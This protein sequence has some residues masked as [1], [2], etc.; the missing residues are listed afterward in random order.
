MGAYYNFSGLDRVEKNLSKMIEQTYPDEFKQMV[1]QVAYELQGLVKTKT[2]VDTSRLRDGWKVGNVK[3]KGN[4]YYIEVYTNIEYSQYVEY[5][6]RKRVAKGKVKGSNGKV[7]GVK[8]LEISLSEMNDR[9][10]NYLKDWLRD[11][12]RTHD[13]YN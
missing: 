1:V 6:H 8:M 4:G 10:P 13:F 2:P 7:E 12:M 9:L 3:K 5:G 11:F